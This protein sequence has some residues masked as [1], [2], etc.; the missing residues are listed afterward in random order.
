VSFHTAP[1]RA[2][3]DRVTAGHRD[4]SVGRDIKSLTVLRPRLGNFIQFVDAVE[5]ILAQRIYNR[6]HDLTRYAIESVAITWLPCTLHA[7]PETGR[8]TLRHGLR[9]RIATCGGSRESCYGSLT[10]KESTV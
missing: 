9:A 6:R 7:Y 3:V 4:S 5:I 1:M 2:R 10:I 8:V